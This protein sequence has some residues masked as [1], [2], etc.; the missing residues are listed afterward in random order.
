MSDVIS[1]F[2]VGIGIQY[3]DSGSKKFNESLSG[4]ESATLRASSVLASAFTAAGAVIDNN[5]R[6]IA[7]VNLEAGRMSA[8]SLYVLQYGAAIQRMGGN[9]DDAIQNLQTLDRIMDDLHTRGRSDTL[10]ELAQAGFNVSYLSQATDAPDLNERIANEYSHANASQR[11]V[12]SGILGTDAATAN[13][14][15]GGGD[16]LRQQIDDAGNLTNINQQLIDQSAKYNQNLRDAQTAWDGLVNTATQQYLPIL[17]SIAQKSEQ[18]FK[19]L[20]SWVQAHPQAAN[21]AAQSGTTVAAGAAVSTAAGIL[22]KLG[23]PGLGT[24]ASRALPATALVAGG[25]YLDREYV[26]PFEERHPILHQL[27]APLNYLND[28][29]PRDVSRYIHSNFFGNNLAADAKPKSIYDP[30]TFNVQPV[31]NNDHSVTTH[32]AHSDNAGDTHNNYHGDTVH[33]SD[34]YTFNDSKNDYEII[35]PRKIYGASDVG[36]RQDD[37]HYEKQAQATTQALQAAPITVNN[38]L[39]AR[40]FMDGREIDSRIERHEQ[41]LNQN[42]VNAHQSRADR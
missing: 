30:N 3:D 21:A 20:D 7:N 2:L 22:T 17:D 40:L 9:A 27:A 29:L 24:L 11:R 10:N 32:N 5:A 34:I 42:T 33:S 13:L 4:I 35:D 16:Y 1:S 26:A 8:S 36:H 18:A 14:Y 41:R 6:H 15:A 28:G 19:S 39:D 31:V 37:S 23:V 38:Q 12:A 25:Q